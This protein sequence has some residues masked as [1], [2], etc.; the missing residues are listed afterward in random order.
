MLEFIKRLLRVRLLLLSG[1]LQL[2]R[3]KRGCGMLLKRG[4]LKAC[5]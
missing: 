2:I 5:L 3:G 4:L 1:L